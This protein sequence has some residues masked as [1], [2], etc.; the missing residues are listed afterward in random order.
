MSASSVRS[1]L[2]VLAAAAVFGLL[3]PA[4]AAAQSGATALPEKYEF[5][6]GG[7]NATFD[8]LFGLKLTNSDNVSIV[9]FERDLGS[10]DSN[11]VF[12]GSAAI[13][14]GKHQFRAGY[15]KTSRESTKTL[16]RQIV[17]GDQVFTI[18]ASVGSSFSTSFP[19]VDYTYW[20]VSSPK[21]AAGATLGVTNFGV[22][23]GVNAA[24]N[25][26]NAAAQ[27]D[28]SVIVPLFGAELRVLPANWFVVKAGGGYINDFSGTS[29]WRLG[30]GVEPRIYKS[31]WLGVAFDAIK[32]NVSQDAA[33]FDLNAAGNLRIGGVQFYARLGF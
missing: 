12:R 20:F 27:V 10:P 3:P 25:S 13:R 32:F 21:V 22:E 7:F 11:T 5:V 31:L 8:T 1:G 19:E 6:I 4:P 28:Q 15:Y 2:A 30:A 26:R 17:W 16:D 33:L 9:D 29:V 23:L 24:L 14:F 18:G